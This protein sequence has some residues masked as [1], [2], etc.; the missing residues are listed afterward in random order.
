[1]SFEIRRP[2][3]YDIVSVTTII[4]DAEHI[5]LFYPPD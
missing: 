3:L 2:V 4:K 1:V 5:G